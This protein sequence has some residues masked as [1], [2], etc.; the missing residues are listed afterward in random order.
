M[1]CDMSLATSK[2]SPYKLS[3][4]DDHAL[5]NRHDVLSVC[6][7]SSSLWLTGLTLNFVIYAAGSIS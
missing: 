6:Q 5:L 2:K 3:H 4:L 7:E 1:I